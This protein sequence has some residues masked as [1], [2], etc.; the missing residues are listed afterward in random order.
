VCGDS[1]LHDHLVADCFFHEA[2]CGKPDQES[3]GNDRGDD[4]Q[5]NQKQNA[6]I[7]TKRS[8]QLFGEDAHNEI[9][10]RI[11]SADESESDGAYPIVHENAALVKFA[12]ISAIQ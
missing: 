6:L 12:V 4:Q 1:C 10:W 2:P 11:V 7:K 9:P 5:S 3:G 8:E